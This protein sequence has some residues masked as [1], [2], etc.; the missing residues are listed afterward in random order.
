[1]STLGMGFITAGAV[2][3]APRL[4]GNN[5]WRY[6]NFRRKFDQDNSNFSVESR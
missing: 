2:W 3:V 6:H 4:L 5:S 1:M